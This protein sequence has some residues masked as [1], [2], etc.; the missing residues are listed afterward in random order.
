[1]T[2]GDSHR[3]SCTMKQ[4]LLLSGYARSGKD[5]AANLLEEEHGYRR[6]AFAD[7]LK[8]MVSTLTGIPVALFHS[9]QKDSVIPGP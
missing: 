2:G 6:F 4:I 1:M 5:S 9:Q 7:A 8:E 3:I